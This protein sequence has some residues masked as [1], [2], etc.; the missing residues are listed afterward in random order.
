MGPE[1]FNSPLTFHFGKPLNVVA[2]SLF[3]GL[4]FFL[5][6]APD[7]ILS[8]VGVACVH[9]CNVC[10]SFFQS[11]LLAACCPGDEMQTWGSVSHFVKSSGN[12]VFVVCSFLLF[13]AYNGP[14]TYFVT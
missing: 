5:A 7:V 9:A 4:M 13:R 3:M 6:N 12:C 14:T 10:I 8:G 1:I 2:V 11:E